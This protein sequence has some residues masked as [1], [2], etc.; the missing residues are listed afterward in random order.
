MHGP[1]APGQ[2]GTLCELQPQ[3]AKEAATITRPPK[4]AAHRLDC[5]AA[6][7]LRERLNEAPRHAPE[8]FLV[9]LV[10]EDGAADGVPELGQQDLHLSPV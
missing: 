2:A 1:C 10:W 5:A 8:A 7:V 3:A 4:E 9:P 6:G